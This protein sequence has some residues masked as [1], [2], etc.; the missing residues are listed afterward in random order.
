[1]RVKLNNHTKEAR[2]ED[3]VV[4]ENRY[5][6]LHITYIVV[7]QKR[8]ERKDTQFLAQSSNENVNLKF[9]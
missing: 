1:M 6:I 5:Y 7:I 3:F 2:P 8:G 9:T 4:D